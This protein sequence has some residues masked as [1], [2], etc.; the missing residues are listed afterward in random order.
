MPCVV[1]LT[2]DSDNMPWAVAVCPGQWLYGLASGCTPWAFAVHPF[3][4]QKTP[5]SNAKSHHYNSKTYFNGIIKYLKTWFVTNR[6]D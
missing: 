1:D 5:K 2:L 3:T 6:T 4:N